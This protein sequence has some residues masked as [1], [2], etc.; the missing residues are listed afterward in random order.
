MIWRNDIIIFSFEK[1]YILFSVFLFEHNVNDIVVANMTTSTTG[2]KHSTCPINTKN[3]HATIFMFSALVN[4][5]PFIYFLYER[6][7]KIF[8]QRKNQVNVDFLIRNF[9]I[10]CSSKRIQMVHFSVLNHWVS[11]IARS[12]STKKKIIKIY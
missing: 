12:L 6:R 9:I 4:Y 5:F 11:L 1:N 7:A 3:K 10:R 8:C 2:N